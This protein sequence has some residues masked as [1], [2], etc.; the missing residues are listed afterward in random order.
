MTTIFLSD[1]TKIKVD[2]WALEAA[3]WISRW[4]WTLVKDLPGYNLQPDF[5]TGGAVAADL[6]TAFFVFGAAQLIPFS[7]MQAL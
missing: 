5:F 7:I 6:Q 2:S 1:A 4:K 3:D